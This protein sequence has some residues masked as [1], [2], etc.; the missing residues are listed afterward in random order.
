MNHTGRSPYFGAQ[1]GVEEWNLRVVVRLYLLLPIGSDG[2]MRAYANQAPEEGL[3]GG[4]VY[5]ER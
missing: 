5:K 3:D 2:T 1:T 4:R